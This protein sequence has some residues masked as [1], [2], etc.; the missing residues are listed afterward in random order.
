[1][2]FTSMVRTLRRRVQH[3]CLGSGVWVTTLDPFQ[4]QVARLYYEKG[5]FRFA[6]VGANDGVSFD[7]LYWLVKRFQGRGLVIEPLEDA[8][9]RLRHNYRAMPEVIPIRAAVH[10]TDSSVDIYRVRKSSLTNVPAW[11]YGSASMENSWLQRQGVDS[12]HVERETV[13][14]KPL[15]ELLTENDMCDIDVLQ[16]DTE[17]FDHDVLGMIDFSRCKP[18]IIKYERLAKHVPDSRAREEAMQ[19]ALKSRGYTIVDFN[20]DVIAVQP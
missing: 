13:P 1:M 7:D 2:V 6:Q 5:G 4:R 14:A 18:R 3:L 12:G 9:D 19:R 8:F 20:M 15:M 11:A 16:V 10:P 17:G